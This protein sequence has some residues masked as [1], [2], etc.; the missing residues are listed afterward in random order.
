MKRWQNPEVLVGVKELSLRVG[1]LEGQSQKNGILEI[2][3]LRVASIEN[4]ELQGLTMDM[5][6]R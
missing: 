2:E 6:L 4:T 5:G 3:I 1:L